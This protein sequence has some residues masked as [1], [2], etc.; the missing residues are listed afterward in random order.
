[1]TVIITG[2][3]PMQRYNM[4]TYHHSTQFPRGGA[5]FTLQYN[6]GPPQLLKQSSNGPDPDPPLIH[7]EVVSADD[8]GEIRFDMLRSKNDGARTDAHMDLNGLEIHHLSGRL[9]IQI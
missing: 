8:Q 2:L 7:N 5:G 4:R 3:Q 6:G 9:R 1:M